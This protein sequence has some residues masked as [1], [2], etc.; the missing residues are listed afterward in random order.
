MLHFSRFYDHAVPEIAIDGVVPWIVKF[1]ESD[2]SGFMW[3][4]GDLDN[5]HLELI[6]LHNGG[7]RYMVLVSFKE[8]VTHIESPMPRRLDGTRCVQPAAP[9]EM[10]NDLDE[11]L[12]FPLLIEDVPSALALQCYSDGVRLELGGDGRNSPIW[13]S[14]GRVSFGLDSQMRLAAIEIA[15]IDAG[16][17]AL[18]KAGPSSQARHR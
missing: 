14:S 5:T 12:V 13:V 16:T 11:S 18:M 7:L 17:M 15:D 9:T 1:D 2:G 10:W 3:R 6:F 8:E 4:T